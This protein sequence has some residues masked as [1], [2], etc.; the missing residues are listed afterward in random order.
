M[1]DYNGGDLY[2]RMMMVRPPVELVS[3]GVGAEMA[4]VMGY[5]VV[6][7]AVKGVFLCL[8]REGWVKLKGVA[9]GVWW[10]AVGVVGASFVGVVVGGA[11]IVGMSIVAG[12]V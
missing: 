11:A 12:D 10:V 8:I 3:I 6:V 9:R 5:V 4:L 2:T 7:W 1:R